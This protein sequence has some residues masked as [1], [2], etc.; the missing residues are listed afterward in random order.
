MR[1]VVHTALIIGLLYE[2]VIVH[3][4]EALYEIQL[5][6]TI[7]HFPLWHTQECSRCAASLSQASEQ[8]ALL[9]LTRTVLEAEQQVVEHLVQCVQDRNVS[10]WPDG[11]FNTICYFS[12]NGLSRLLCHES[13][14]RSFRSHIF[15]F[16]VIYSQVRTVT[17][18]VYASTLV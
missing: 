7:N 15:R 13:F 8:T 2:V 10:H 5:L 6:L 1:F 17:Q 11:Q 12:S 14:P 18:H 16:S 3:Q 4:G 9:S